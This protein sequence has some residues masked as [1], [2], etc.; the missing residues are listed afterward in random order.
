MFLC[1]CS[2]NSSAQDAA[3]FP[4]TGTFRLQADPKKPADFNKVIIKKDGYSVLM[5]D[6]V[7]RTYRLLS[8]GSEG[9]RVEQVFTG[10]GSEK[11]DKPRFTVHLDKENTKDCFITVIYG[12]RTDKIHL[13]RI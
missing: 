11:K 12:N 3:E 10:P 1:V 13:V 7:I 6:K 5:D 9:F 2:F 4:L 8:K